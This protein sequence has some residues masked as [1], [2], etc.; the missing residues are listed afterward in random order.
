MRHVVVG[1]GIIGALLAGSTVEA[2][3]YV[4]TPGEIVFIRQT[5]AVGNV[6][7][8]DPNGGPFRL[9]VM[10]YDGLFPPFSPNGEDIL[11]FCLELNE[12][13][14]YNTALRVNQITGSAFL[15]GIGGG[16][17]DPISPQTDFLFNMW[18]IGAAGYTNGP[19]VQRVIWFFEDEGI[20]ITPGSLEDQL[21]TRVLTDMAN[22]VPKPF[23]TL[24]L[25]LFVD[26]TGQ[27]HQDVLVPGDPV[28]E[29]ASLVL[30]GSGLLAVGLRLRRRRSR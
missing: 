30:V 11:T 26:A 25:D 21:I 19:V 23:S 13:R 22:G 29:P 8:N 17:P 3:P 20:V 1:A 15:G 24:V 12:P 4:F 2:A 7:L 6:I 27:R 28:P 18:Y 9:D 10:P 14:L 5:N 16:S